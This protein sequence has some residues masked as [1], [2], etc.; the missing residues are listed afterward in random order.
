MYWG[1]NGHGEAGASHI[2]NDSAI[3]AE[4]FLSF[5]RLAERP[6][7]TMTDCF[8]LETRNI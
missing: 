8:P 1:Y 2:L 4:L 3:W 7:F 5:F 6:C